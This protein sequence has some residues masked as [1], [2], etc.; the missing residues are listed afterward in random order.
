MRFG[1]V[2]FPGSNCDKDAVFAAREC[3]GEDAVELWHKDATVPNSVDCIILPGG[4]SYGDYLRSGAIA[5][6]SPIMKDV[7]RFVERGGLAIGIC[8][9]FQ[10]MTETGIL[11][12]ALTRNAS[13][14]FVCKDTRVKTLNNSTPLTS[15][16]KENE[17]LRIPIAHGEGNYFA[18][19]DVVKRLEDNEQIVFKYCDESGAFTKEANP[20]GSIA[21]IAGIVNEKGNA[22]GMMPHPE[23]YSDSILGCDDGKKIFE[24]IAS[25]FK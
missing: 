20:N 4:F 24:S 15:K 10:V 23:R 3:A 5:K 12:G 13:L 6:F 17:I 8:N 18:E 1:I 2:V 9:G 16:L 21:N 7:V 19:E 25:Y 14:N 11:P 22:L